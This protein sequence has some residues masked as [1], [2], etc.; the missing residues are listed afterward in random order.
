MKGGRGKG[1]EN[2]TE[3]RRLQSLVGLGAGDEQER[4][5]EEGTARCSVFLGVRPCK[6]VP[7]NICA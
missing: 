5:T 3:G 4:A 1:K 6:F 2:G 7:E